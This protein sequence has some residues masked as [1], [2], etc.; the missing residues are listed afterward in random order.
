[1]KRL[2]VPYQQGQYKKEACI[3]K[4]ILFILI[5]LGLSYLIYKNKDKVKNWAIYLKDK[6]INL[7]KKNK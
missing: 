7:F 5:F 4:I 1:M 6:Y 3:I 2:D